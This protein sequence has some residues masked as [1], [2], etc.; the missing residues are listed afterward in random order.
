MKRILTV[1]LAL[2]GAA[3]AHPGHAGTGFVSG[4]VH[5]WTGIDHLV[6]LVSAG[7]WAFRAGGTAR[8]IVPPL[9]LL[10][11]AAGFL[12]SWTGSVRPGPET[13][14]L[15]GTAGLVVAALFGGRLPLVLPSSLV[16]AL[17]HGMAHGGEAPSGSAGPDF[18][19]GFLVSAAALQLFGFLAGFAARRALL[20][21]SAPADRFPAGQALPESV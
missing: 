13:W 12:L 8:R 5:P 16:A 10:A 11:M 17:L 20:R 14:T 3:A 21:A 9:F 4:L 15:A 18:L 1:T 6:A 19:A 7:V 2:A